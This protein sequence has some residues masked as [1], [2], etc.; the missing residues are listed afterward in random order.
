MRNLFYFLPVLTTRACVNKY[1]VPQIGGNYRSGSRSNVLQCRQTD[2]AS[3]PNPFM[4]LPTPLISPTNRPGADE[5][6]DSHLFSLGNRS[7]KEAGF[8]VT[9]LFTQNSSKWVCR[10]EFQLFCCKEIKDLQRHLLW[11]QSY[12][13]QTDRCHRRQPMS[14]LI[15][16]TN[17]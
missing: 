15:L 17:H 13:R 2:R 1:G 14:H 7:T 16:P 10:S 6:S 5:S 12:C 9:S 11:N 8:P 4:D 3:L